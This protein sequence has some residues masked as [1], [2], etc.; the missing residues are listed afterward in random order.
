MQTVNLFYGS[1]RFFQAGST[2]G[3]ESY[4]IPSA[5]GGMGGSSILTRGRLMMQSCADNGAYE[6]ARVVCLHSKDRESHIGHEG[7][8]RSGRSEGAF[9]AFFMDWIRPCA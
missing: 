7:P 4:K 2:V 8:Q 3:P 1:A 5:C 6:C 9:V